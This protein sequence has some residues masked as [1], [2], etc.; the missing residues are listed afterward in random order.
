[1][2]ELFDGLRKPRRDTGRSLE[3]ERIVSL[4][5]THAPTQEEIDAFSMEVV[6]ASYFDGGFRLFGTQVQAIL[7][8]MQCKGAFCPIGVGWG[9]TLISL[10]VADY[11][12]R[13][14]EG[15]DR[16]ALYVPPQVYGQLTNTD[17]QWA[18]NR[19]GLRVP[20]IQ[21]GGRSAQERM[22]AARSG[23]KGL[24]IM[25]Y[26]QLS[27]RDAEDL[28]NN[29]RPDLVILDEAHNVKNPR[30]ARTRRLMR[31]L[32]QRQPQLVALSG[33]ITSKSIG[34]YHHLISHALGENSPLPLS[35]DL[36]S[37]WGMALDADADP[38]E[39]QCGPV[40]PLIEWAN[41]RFPLW[42]SASW[43]TR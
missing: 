3:I 6:D 1:M 30:A 22:S 24:Y 12:F 15:V 36:A 19:V 25:P 42:G 2:S 11:A 5:M 28:L 32:D 35:T 14:E 21:M 9:K 7:E 34:D 37:N 43:P 31:Y 17:I 23:K 16:I 41:W 18:R 4:P 13:E 33:T 38:T 39:A 8:Y 29:I 26:S 27:T 40:Q 10:M 20:I